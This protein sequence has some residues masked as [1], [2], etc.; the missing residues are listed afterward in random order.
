MTTTDNAGS[1]TPQPRLAICTARSKE[2]AACRLILD[3]PA[4]VHPASKG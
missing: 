1:G 2:L 4:P 3:D